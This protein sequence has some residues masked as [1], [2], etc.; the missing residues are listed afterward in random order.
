MKWLMNFVAAVCVASSAHG[1]PAQVLDFEQTTP[2]QL[3]EIL[4]GWRE[5]YEAGDVLLKSKETKTYEALLRN[6][7]HELSK[8]ETW[9]GL[10]KDK[11]VEVVNMYEKL[12]VLT[13]GGMTRGSR[14]ICS[15]DKRRGSN[16]RQRVCITAAEQARIEKISKA[17]MYDIER[18]GRRKEVGGN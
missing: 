8:R 9:Q 7:E 6:L 18:N 10:P 12:R 2:H 3:T 1:K 14:R 13:D 4:V 17:V 16:L 11:S 15:F 5:K